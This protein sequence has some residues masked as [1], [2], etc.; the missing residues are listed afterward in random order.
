MAWSLDDDLD[1]SKQVAPFI[2]GD[3]AH[4][5]LSVAQFFPENPLAQ[6]QL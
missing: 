2:Q 1:E 4:S 3:D 6:A 5:S